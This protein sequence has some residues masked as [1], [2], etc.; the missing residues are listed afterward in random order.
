MSHV[1]AVCRAIL[2]FFIFA[3]PHEI[4]G[5]LLFMISVDKFTDLHPCRCMWTNKERNG[6]SYR[7]HATSGRAFLFQQQP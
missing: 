6:P 5:W 7:E 3:E 1:R 2:Y 4:C